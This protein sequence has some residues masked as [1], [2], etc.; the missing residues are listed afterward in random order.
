MLDIS[1]MWVFSVCLV[2]VGGTVKR[3]ASQKQ[4]RDFKNK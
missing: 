2:A 3:Q 1:G 4:Q